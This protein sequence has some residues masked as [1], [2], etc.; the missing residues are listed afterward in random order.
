MFIICAYSFSKSTSNKRIF[1]RLGLINV[2]NWQTRKRDWSKIIT[3]PTELVNISANAK[4]MNFFK[5]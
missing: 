4:L 3:I 2:Y 1:E 5:K